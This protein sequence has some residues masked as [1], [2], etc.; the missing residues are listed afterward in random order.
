MGYVASRNLASYTLEPA[1]DGMIGT[2]DNAATALSAGG[3]VSGLLFTSANR[4]APYL[5]CPKIHTEDSHRSPPPHALP[6][7][8]DLTL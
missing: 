2:S 4:R 7:S 5:D 6:K 1:I 8:P 3:S